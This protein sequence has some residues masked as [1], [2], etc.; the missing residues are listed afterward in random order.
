M[1]DQSLLNRITII[2]TLCYGKPTIRG[3]RYTVQSIL[4]YLASGMSFD[5]FLR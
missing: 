5:T 3:L 1:D 4:E 2:P